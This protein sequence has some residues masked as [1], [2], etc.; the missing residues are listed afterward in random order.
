MS[1]GALVTI[2]PGSFQVCVSIPVG[3]IA[4][5]LA[6]IA[7]H[8]VTRLDDLLPWNWRKEAGLLSQ[9]A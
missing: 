8:P 1:L 5:I 7:G 6:R 3:L 2:R 9:T 4:D